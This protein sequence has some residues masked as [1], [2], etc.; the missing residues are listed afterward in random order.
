MT[1]SNIA[2]LLKNLTPTFFSADERASFE[3]SKFK[4]SDHPDVPMKSYEANSEKD[5]V[6]DIVE[7]FIS[8]FYQFLHHFSLESFRI[9]AQ[10]IE[11]IP[12]YK[13]VHM[14]IFKQ[15]F[16]SI[17]EPKPRADSVFFQF[18]SYFFSV[19]AVFFC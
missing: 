12:L 9:I 4:S 14:T 10:S 7:F 19:R 1:P 2:I 18:F 5:A 6:N 15:P 3:I 16:M 11:R 17:L 13:T 8:G